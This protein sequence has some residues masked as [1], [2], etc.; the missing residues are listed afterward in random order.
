MTVLKRMWNNSFTLTVDRLPVTSYCTYRWEAS[1]AFLVPWWSSSASEKVMLRRIDDSWLNGTD[2]F[3]CV[4]EMV[5]G[6]WRRWDKSSIGSC[7]LWS[8]IEKQNT[9][10]YPSISKRKIWPWS[11]WSIRLVLHHINIKFLLSD[12]SR[13][14]SCQQRYELIGLCKMHDTVEEHTITVYHLTDCSFH[15]ISR[16]TLWE[17][18]DL[19]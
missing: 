5:R 7:Q 9:Y 13:T 4:R 10:R 16:G 14:M 12:N 15:K 19:P 6:V 11:I 1:L 18:P 2:K 17:L 8:T 3:P